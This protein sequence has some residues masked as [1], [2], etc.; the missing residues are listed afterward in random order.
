L[1]PRAVP[2][3]LS[4]LLLLAYFPVMSALYLQSRYI[5]LASELS[6]KR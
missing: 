3:Q 5:I 1:S 4:S 2:A 6:Q